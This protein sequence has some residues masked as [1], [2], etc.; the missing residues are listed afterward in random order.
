MFTLVSSTLTPCREER[1][2]QNRFY[3]SFDGRF[4]EEA[5]T[6]EVSLPEPA[7]EEERT[8]SVSYIFSQ[9]GA[10]DGI[11]KLPEEVL[12][13]L[14]DPVSGINENETVTP[15]DPAARTIGSWIFLGWEPKSQTIRDQ[16]VTFSGLWK[17]TDHVSEIF[18][19]TVMYKATSVLYSGFGTIAWGLHSRGGYT[20]TYN[21]LLGG[22][23][24]YCIQTDKTV[25]AAGSIY[26]YIGEDTSKIA[27]IISKGTYYGMSPGAIQA[28]VW[29]YLKSDKT[30]AW[31]DSGENVDYDSKYYSAPGQTCSIEVYSPGNTNYQKQGKPEPCPDPVTGK[32]QIKKHPADTDFD[33]IKNCPNNYSLAGAEYGV[34]KNMECTDRVALLKTKNS[35]KTNEKELKPGTY[36]VKELKPSPGFQLD[37]NI[38]TA[39]VTLSKTTVVDSYEPPL[40]DPFKMVLYKENARN[41][42]DVSFLEEA[43]FTLKYYDTQKDDVENIRPSYTW[44]FRPIINEDLKAEVLFDADHYLKG[45]ELLLDENGSFFIPIGTFTIEESKAPSTFARDENIYLGHIIYENGSVSTEFQGTQDLQVNGQFIT[46]SE[47]KQAIILSVQK[48]D[49]ET[50]E[51]VAQGFGSL[52]NA[53]FSVSRLNE[54]SGNKEKVGTII[55][56]RDGK[57]SLS[58]DE[59][60]EELLPGIYYIQE[61]EASDGYLVNGEEFQVEAYIREE[62]TAVFEYSVEIEEQVTEIVVTK[63]DSLGN[64]L[65]GAELEILDEDGKSVY[66]WISSDEPQVIKGLAFGKTYTIRERKTPDDSVYAYAGDLEIIIDENR[67]E[68]EIINGIVAIHTSASF[69]DTKNKNH[70]ADGITQITDTVTYEW[71]Y[72]GKKYRLIGQLINKESKE[73]LMENSLEFVP[74]NTHGSA[75]VDFWIDLEGHDEQD[76]VVYEELYLENEEGQLQ[77]IISHKDLNDPEQTVRIDRLYRTEMVLYKTNTRKTVKLNGALFHVTSRRIR[78]DGS[79]CEKDLGTFI[80]GGIYLEKKEPFSFY[81]SQ[82]SYMKNEVQTFDSRLNRDGMYIVSITSLE[83]GTYY[84]KTDLEDDIEE[85]PVSKGAIILKGQ[86]EETEITYTEIAAPKG[87]YIDKKAYTVNVGSDHSLEKIENYRTN[88]AIILPETG[89]ERGNDE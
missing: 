63:K 51:T 66:S 5:D 65:E 59:N 34:Y 37:E 25:P 28:T 47:N 4:S 84:G 27:E 87:Y 30:Y 89:I 69:A 42:D 21:F 72:P 54:E 2:H 11:G 7:E 73:V 29:N 45:D 53:V 17:N 8:Y 32:L 26:N 12:E 71:L 15:E 78:N 49:K 38:Y 86:A 40:N 6:E 85:Y 76:F 23:Q 74:E 22:E 10:Y 81:L 41:R 35:G 31:V 79:L 56:D 57:G 14:P 9:A 80:T 82:D 33:Y 60:G 50:Q 70:V 55:T 83:D 67:R 18:K 39:K 13:L 88:I 61:T 75:N 16:D 68:Y 44:V 77:L 24:S 43:E 62:N 48:F 1:F 20:G 3:A 19:N 46:Q 36:Y 58:R 52:E 64:Y